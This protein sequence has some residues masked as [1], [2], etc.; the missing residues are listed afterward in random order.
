MKIVDRK[1][2]LAMP[3]GTV[4]GV[5]A[6]MVGCLPDK[7]E[8]KGKTWTNDWLYYSLDIPSHDSGEFMDN[9]HLMQT[10]GAEFPLEISLSRD[11]CFSETD[12]YFILDADDIKVLKD[13]YDRKYVE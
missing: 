7:F 11:G 12:H 5:T 10:T 13:Y 8:V 9:I 6:E 4:Y 3:P 1:T 2:F